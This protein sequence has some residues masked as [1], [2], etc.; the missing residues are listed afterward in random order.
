MLKTRDSLDRTFPNQLVLIDDPYTVTDTD[1]WGTAEPLNIHGELYSSYLEPFGAFYRNTPD[2]TRKRVS[3]LSRSRNIRYQGKVGGPVYFRPRDQFP[4]E[5][6]RISRNMTL[7]YDLT[8]RGVQILKRTGRYHPIKHGGWKDHQIATGCI[9]ASLHLAM[10]HDNVPFITPD[11]IA[12][13]LGVTVPYTAPDGTHY[14]DHRLVFDYIFGARRRVHPIETDL[15]SEVGR[16][17]TKK[18]DTEQFRRR[19]SYQRM[20]FQYSELILR[21]QPDGGKLYNKAFRIP[22]ENGL[23]PLFITTSK[24]KVQLMKDII[25]EFTDGE[26]CNWFLMKYVPAKIFSAYESPKPLLELWTGPWE[27]AGRSDFYINNPARQ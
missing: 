1:I 18:P 10:L 17:G 26:G 23:M 6:E 5:K 12:D 16:A 19:K 3:W 9:T 2:Y 7:R 24:S 27:R 21:S 11:Y 13:D 15:G 22:R 14:K 8:E 20:Y 25:L 4:K